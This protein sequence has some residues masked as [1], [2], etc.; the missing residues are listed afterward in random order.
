MEDDVYAPPDSAFEG[1]HRGNY[2]AGFSVLKSFSEGASG[3][4]RDPASAII[5]T[6]LFVVL[7]G[8]A[9][10]VLF[11]M[12]GVFAESGD[13]T[14]VLI[15]FSFLI[16]FGSASLY[17][18]YRTM[19]SGMQMLGMNLIRNTSRIEDL[20]SG[21]LRIWRI[22][23]SALFIYFV[24]VLVPIL[25]LTPLIFLLAFLAGSEM[26]G[27]DWDQLESDPTFVTLG[28]VL[29]GF[30]LVLALKAYLD[31]RLLLVFPLILERNLRV[32][33]AITKSWRMTA[34]HHLW[35]TVLVML[36]ELVFWAGALCCGIGAVISVP[37]HYAVFGSASIQLLGDATAHTDVVRD[38]SG[39]TV[40]SPPPPFTENE[41]PSASPYS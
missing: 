15:G 22:S 10:F 7:M 27:D 12:F 6:I 2:G 32:F 41:P 4:R 30:L 23:G 21:F 19:Q 31:G 29:P 40:P 8:A 34:P 18:L 17:I 37:L 28:L 35:L 39:P 3:F 1:G 11:V 5:G 16:I 20:F 25:V 9:Y 13:S 36:N 26:F 33:E 38:S 14:P 24:Q